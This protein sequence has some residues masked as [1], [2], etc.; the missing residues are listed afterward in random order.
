MIDVGIVGDPDVRL[1]VTQHPD[2]SKLFATLSHCWGKS[3]FLTLCNDSFE[4]FR[5]GIELHRL[6]KTFREAI[7][8][9]RKFGLRYLWI[10]SLCKKLA[11]DTQSVRFAVAWEINWIEQVSFKT[12]ETTGSLNR[13]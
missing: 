11:L 12:L 5:S 13:H 10:D 3:Q 8:V 9:V 4:E 1:V 6:P 7:Y 2:C